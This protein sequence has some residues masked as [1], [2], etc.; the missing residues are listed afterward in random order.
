VTI[1]KA[2]EWK[3]IL[4]QVQYIMSFSGRM[5]FPCILWSLKFYYFV[6]KN[7]AWGSVVVKALR[8]WSGGLG[9]DPHWCHWGFFS[10]ATDGTI[11]PGVDSATKNEYQEN[12]WE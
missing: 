12:S 11:C 6:P 2:T 9:I 7:G 1:S 5:E 3:S 8:C 4:W 10:E